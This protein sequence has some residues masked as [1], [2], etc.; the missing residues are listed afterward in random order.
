MKQIIT[1]THRAVLCLEKCKKFKESKL[2][3]KL[4]NRGL[5]FFMGSILVTKGKASE[6]ALILKVSEDAINLKINRKGI[7][8]L[9]KMVLYEHSGTN[10]HV[11]SL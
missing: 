6:D 2:M 7:S 1:K 11:C 9:M 4:W 5:L 8:R 10:F 3:M